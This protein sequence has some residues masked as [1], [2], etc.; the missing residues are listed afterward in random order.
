MAS[1]KEK[2]EHFMFQE[3]DGSLIHEPGFIEVW[4]EKC[5]IV[6]KFFVIINPDPANDPVKSLELR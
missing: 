4:I 3:L 1:K 5:S 6:K 2:W